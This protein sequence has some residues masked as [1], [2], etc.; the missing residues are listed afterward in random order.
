MVAIVLNE[1][2]VECLTAHHLFEVS[3]C[4]LIFYSKNKSGLLKVYI[5]IPFTHVTVYFLNYR[6]SKTLWVNEYAVECKPHVE[7]LFLNC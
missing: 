4:F 5:F 3:S 6:T 7:V 2:F 1:S